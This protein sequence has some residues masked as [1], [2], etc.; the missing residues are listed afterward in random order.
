MTCPRLVLS[1]P[2]CAFKQVVSAKVA[3]AKT[4]RAQSGEDEIDEE[5]REDEREE[6]KNRNDWKP[7]PG[8]VFLFHDHDNDE[9]AWISMRHA[10][11]ISERVDMSFTDKVERAAYRLE[12]GI[13]R[14][15]KRR[16]WFAKLT[17]S[18]IAVT[19]GAHFRLPRDFG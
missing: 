9:W 4:E 2:D 7:F 13:Q 15:L 6:Q 18:L 14:V 12:A 8:N 1:G 3:K 17:R 16:E 10:L 19:F 5:Q 11:A